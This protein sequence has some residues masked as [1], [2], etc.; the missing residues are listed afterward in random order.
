LSLLTMD[1]N[2]YRYLS[3]AD[4][5]Q[6]VAACSDDR[7]SL[8]LWIKSWGP[9][10]GYSGSQLAQSKRPKCRSWVILSTPKDQAC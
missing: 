5:L 9:S 8:H 1:P 4:K 6:Q 10:R 2:L 7:V 3:A